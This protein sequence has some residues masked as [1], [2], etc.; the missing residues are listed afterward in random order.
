MPVFSPRH[1]LREMLTPPLS[2]KANPGNVRWSSKPLTKSSNSLK[3]SSD[4]NTPKTP[5]RQRTQQTPRPQWSLPRA[6]Y[7]YSDSPSS[8]SET[9][10]V[11]DDNVNGDNGGNDVSDGL[12]LGFTDS[13]KENISF[14][15]NINS[16]QHE[17]ITKPTT[18][19]IDRH[20][21][22]P[23]ESAADTSREQQLA[24]KCYDSAMETMGSDALSA[25]S[26]GSVTSNNKSASDDLVISSCEGRECVAPPPE[27]MNDNVSMTS[28]VE[29][30]DEGHIPS[31]SV[32]EENEPQHSSNKVAEAQSPNES[33]TSSDYNREGEDT[34][35]PLPQ[36][37]DM[38]VR[39]PI[40]SVAHS[41]FAP[42]EASSVAASSVVTDLFA[43]LRTNCST[44]CGGENDDED[45]TTEKCHLSPIH[46]REACLTAERKKWIHKTLLSKRE[47]TPYQTKE[48]EECCKNKDSHELTT[49][50]KKWIE[51]TLLTN[52]EQEMVRK[53]SPK[54]THSTFLASAL[55]EAGNELFAQPKWHVEEPFSDE[56][57]DDSTVASSMKSPQQCHQ[58]LDSSFLASALV[59]T[60]MLLTPPRRE[61]YSSKPSR[62]R[63]SI[64]ATPLPFA[65]PFSPSSA[66]SSAFTET[67]SNIILHAI[68]QLTPK[69][70]SAISKQSKQK[71]KTTTPSRKS[72]LLSIVAEMDYFDTVGSHASKYD[73]TSQCDPTKLVERVEKLEQLITGQYNRGSD[74]HQE[75][76]N[77]LRRQLDNER[78]LVEEANQRASMLMSN[79]KA[80]QELHSDIESQLRERIQSL[81]VEVC[82]LRESQKQ[83]ASDQEKT[84]TEIVLESE[85]SS[86]ELDDLRRENIGLLEKQRT[87]EMYHSECK[88][89]NEVLRSQL[90]ALSN[91][92]SEKEQLLTSAVDNL[93][94]VSESFSSINQKLEEEVNTKKDEV[95][96]MQRSLELMSCELIEST[97]EVKDLRSENARL[98]DELKRMKAGKTW[99]F[100]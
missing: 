17:E 38:L 46:P 74:D 21:K 43:A 31:A 12:S 64:G 75:E 3:L 80:S 29:D 77:E 100:S 33:M 10:D 39:S 48:R 11:D 61:R 32:E 65:S 30:N 85:I 8:D 76:I 79:M 67:A 25:V 54:Q 49:V 92:R 68:K 87:A 96:C 84:T 94:S 89:N 24:Q 81:K 97:N 44:V 28:S 2:T 60:N 45:T 20:L 27:F 40:L 9:S 50:R 26:G 58:Q 19:T 56:T 14:Q 35:S 82:C 41:N 22:Q 52:P 16:Q 57:R 53:L 1:N 83:F 5:C 72:D 34:L 7:T 69:Q 66:A 23:V 47:Y 98:H 73:D 90:L 59:A 36:C 91:E 6:H 86:S 37:R 99:L 55:T 93:R 18:T 70:V 78:Q 13:D 62:P 63:M 95:T 71:Q 51:E 4:F 88:K 42:T 15:Y